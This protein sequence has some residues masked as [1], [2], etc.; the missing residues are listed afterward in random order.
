MG[1]RLKLETAER[2]DLKN[3]MRTSSVAVANEH[4]EYTRTAI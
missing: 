3:K 1:S 2:L 4:L